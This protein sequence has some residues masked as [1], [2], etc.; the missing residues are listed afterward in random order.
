MKELEQL[1]QSMEGQK[2]TNQAQENVVGLNGSTTTPF[3]E[4]FTF[5]QY[6]TRGRTMAQEQ[7]QW[8]VAD[9]EVTMVDNHANLKVLSKKQPGQIM[10][11]VVGLQ[12]LKLSILHLNVS[13]LDDMVLYSVSVKVGRKL[14]ITYFF[15]FLIDEIFLFFFCMDGL[16][17][18]EDGC[19]LNTVD[20]IAAAVNQL[21]RTIQEVTFS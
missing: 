11:I 3:A 1:L 21:L 5:P 20:E 7:K 2:R 12:S 17:Q 14:Q 8:A 19:L 18:V 6:T 13:T 9:I 10:K 4:F 15:F 16:E